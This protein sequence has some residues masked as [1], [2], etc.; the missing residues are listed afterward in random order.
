MKKLIPFLLVLAIA[1]GAWFYFQNSQETGS[2]SFEQKASKN[3]TSNA[4]STSSNT[5]SLTG[6]STATTSAGKTNAGTIGSD[7]EDFDG[8]YDDRP[9]AQVYS[10]LDDA[11]AAIKKG[12]LD[13]DDVILEQFVE[14]GE[15]CTWC[16]ELYSTISELMLNKDAN[17]D[18]RAYYSEILAISGKQEN[19]QK[20][21]DSIRETDNEDI[22]DILAES[23][24]L[25]IGNDEIVKYLSDFVGDSNE[26]LQESAVAA[27]TNQGSKLAAEVLYNRALNQDDPLEDYDIGIGLGEVIPEEDTLPFFQDLVLKRDKISQLGVKALLNYGHDG[28][29]RVFDSLSSS[30]N[31]DFDKGMLVD[32]LDHV[33]YDEETESFLKDVIESEATPTAKEF[34][35]EILEQFE[36]EEDDF[37]DDDLEDDDL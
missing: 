27:I 37:E 28:V 23:L 35:K 31:E 8:D 33:I 11:L 24:E 4:T 10:S 18:E 13:Y 32:A 20:L 26:L 17:E 12:A 1:V 5:N 2:L 7:E 14:P 34:A 22:A 3:G 21:V 15:D 9:A 19:I 16:G 25:T 30:P 6:S 36:L 29:V